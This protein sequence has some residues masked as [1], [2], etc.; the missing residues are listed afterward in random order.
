MLICLANAINTAN[1][2][3]TFQDKNESTMPFEFR[4]YQATVTDYD[5]A[6]FKV[7]YLDDGN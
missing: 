7:I 3:F 2:T 1:L 6:P 4:A 5:T